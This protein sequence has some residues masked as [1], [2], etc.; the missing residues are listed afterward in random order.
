FFE[1]EPAGLVKVGDKNVG[2][3]G[4][5]CESQAVDGKK[6]IHGGKSRSLVA[7]DEGM[8]LRQA[9]PERGGFLDKIGIIAGLRPIQ[10]GFQ[11]SL[12]P[13]AGRASIAFNL[14][15]VHGQHFGH[16]QVVGHRA[17]FLY[18]GPYFSWL[19]R[20]APIT[21]E[22]GLAFF[23]FS[24]RWASA[25]YTWACCWRP[26]CPARSCTNIKILELTWVANFSRVCDM[27]VL[28]SAK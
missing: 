5:R 7:I 1:S 9:L 11:Q 21:W 22:R 12:I 8:I 18:N 10:G 25:S 27:K 17:S 20:Y 13:D 16:G 4:V 2:L 14:I 19:A 23:W 15:G 24:M 28:L 3:F 26:S 6:S